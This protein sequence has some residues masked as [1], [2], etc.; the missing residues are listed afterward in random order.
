MLQFQEFDLKTGKDLTDFNPE[1][2]RTP[3]VKS[4]E[5][6]YLEKWLQTH[7]IEPQSLHVANF[8]DGVNDSDRQRLE[9]K[10]K[11]LVCTS[12]KSGYF[13]DRLTAELIAK[14][15]S[16]RGVRPIYADGKRSAHNAVAY[17]SLVVSDGKSATRN[18]AILES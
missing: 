1:G 9:A 7:Q 2:D 14:G 15:D 4:V 11:Y 5:N 13:T 17:G 18:W 3:R 8:Y 10:G 16:N 12:G 6:C